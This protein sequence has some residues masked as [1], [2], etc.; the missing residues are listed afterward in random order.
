M[1][2]GHPAFVLRTKT[3]CQARESIKETRPAPPKREATTPQLLH[4]DL[5]GRSVLIFAL[6]SWMAV[7]ASGVSGCL[8]DTAQRV[9]RS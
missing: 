8:R 9:K 2:S 5:R 4:Q 1:V 6:A 3:Q 7:R